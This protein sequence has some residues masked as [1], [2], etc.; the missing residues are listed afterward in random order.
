MKTFEMQTVDGT[1]GRDITVVGG[2]LVP[3]T[4]VDALRQRLH[5]A[6]RL[7]RGEWFLAPESGV[8]WWGFRRQKSVN[9]RQVRNEIER[10]LLADPDVVAL[11]SLDMDFN[12]QTRELRI[13]WSVLSNF[14]TVS[15]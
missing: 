4:N 2:R 3:L 15:S 13:N 5:N 7:H 14:G 9:R 11:N 12:R 10:V 6:L 8:N 1:Q